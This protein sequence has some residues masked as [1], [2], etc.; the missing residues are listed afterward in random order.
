MYSFFAFTQ[1]IVHSLSFLQF[2]GDSDLVGYGINF[3]IKFLN[4]AL[5]VCD[6][7]QLGNKTHDIMKFVKREKLY[8]EN[9]QLQ[10]VLNSYG[11]DAQVPHRAL[12]DARLIY[13]LSTKV[14]KFL[15]R[16]NQK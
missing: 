3:D 6:L 10:T 14:N 9:Y 15:K 1:D 5:K 13:E 8:L 4:N 16:I 7:L 2:I 11:I 12:E